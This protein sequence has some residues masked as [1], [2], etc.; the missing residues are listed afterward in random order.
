MKIISFIPLTGLTFLM[1][2]LPLNIFEKIGSGENY[3]TQEISVLH[4]RLMEIKRSSSCEPDDGR[5]MTTDFT[6]WEKLGA[7]LPQ[8]CSAAPVPSIPPVPPSTPS[9]NDE[10]VLKIRKT[11]VLFHNSIF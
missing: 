4:R 6:D 9:G 1:V 11:K 10:E 5:I 3:Q 8:M 2:H 7:E